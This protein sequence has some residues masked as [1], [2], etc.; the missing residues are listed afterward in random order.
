[1]EVLIH[2][3]YKNR[4]GNI[5]VIVRDLGF[6]TTKLVSKPVKEKLTKDLVLEIVKDYYILSRD[7]INFKFIE[8]PECEEE[9]SI[10]YYETCY[11]WEA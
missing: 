7:E 10:V 6:F 9:V 2:K 11:G 3:F 5:V 8:D 1:M 4:N